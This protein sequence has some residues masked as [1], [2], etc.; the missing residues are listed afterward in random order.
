ML[1][2]FFYNTVLLDKSD[3]YFRGESCRN[4]DLTTIGKTESFNSLQTVKMESEDFQRILQWLLLVRL[5]FEVHRIV[6]ELLVFS[7]LR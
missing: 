6:L 1:T 4:N 5:R 3:F 7:Y 2:K